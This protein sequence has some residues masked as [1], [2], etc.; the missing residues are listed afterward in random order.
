M[1]LGPGKGRMRKVTGME[2][3]C[4]AHH[5]PVLVYITG[6]RLL[7]LAAV[8]PPAEPAAGLMEVENSQN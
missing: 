6:D 5:L 1:G 7:F 8:P 2:R 3:K 4:G